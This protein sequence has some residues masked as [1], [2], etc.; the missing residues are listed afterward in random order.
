ME[1]M[2][3]GKAAGAKEGLGFGLTVLMA[4]GNY[5]KHRGGKW[6]WM[7]QGLRED[8]FQSWPGQN[9]W[10]GEV[11][12]HEAGRCRPMECPT[13]EGLGVYTCWGDG[14]FEQGRY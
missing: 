14:F 9:G 12:S 8:E 6:E 3:F 7:T 5:Q 13:W 11:G 4:E 1:T 10:F 2:E